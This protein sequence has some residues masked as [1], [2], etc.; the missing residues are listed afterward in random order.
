MPNRSAAFAAQGT[1]IT[2]ALPGE[3]PDL[4]ARIGGSTTPFDRT[5]WSFFRDSRIIIGTK[6]ESSQVSSTNFGGIGKPSILPNSR[7]PTRMA[8]RQAGSR[9]VR[10]CLGGFLSDKDAFGTLPGEQASIYLY[11]H[12]IAYG[13]AALDARENFYVPKSAAKGQTSL[14]VFTQNEIRLR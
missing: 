8:A 1:S 5:T 6:R 9:A 3:V 13:K 11:I 10:F 14:E 2:V 4:E 7:I 12:S